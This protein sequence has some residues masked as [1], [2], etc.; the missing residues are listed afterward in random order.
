MFSLITSPKPA[1]VIVSI[2][3]GPGPRT[4]TLTLTWILTFGLSLDPDRL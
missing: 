4:L 3:R 1:S 2:P